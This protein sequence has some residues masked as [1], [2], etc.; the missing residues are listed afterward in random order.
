MHMRP[1]LLCLSLAGCASCFG[2]HSA[3]ALSPAPHQRSVRPALP[4]SEARALTTVNA[5]C[6]TCAH[7]LIL[8]M[9]P[10]IDPKMILKVP[11]SED[12]MPVYKGMPACSQD[13]R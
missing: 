2:Y 3:P 8:R 1:S 7:M 13:F 10:N 11:K 6:G 12:R 9:P 5:T 4:R